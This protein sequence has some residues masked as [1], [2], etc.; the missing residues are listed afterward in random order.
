MR[1]FVLSTLIAAVTMAGSTSITAPA[2]AQAQAPCGPVAYSNAEQKYVGI[3]CTAP[4]PKTEAGQS[5]PCGPVAYSVADQ[6][7]VG[8]P[9][10]H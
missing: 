7:Y 10:T 8:I 5:A 4:T 1:M 9:C 2:V 3:P 6:K